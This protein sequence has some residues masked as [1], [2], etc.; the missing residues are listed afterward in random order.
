MADN[1]STSLTGLDPAISKSIATNA[2]SQGIT[3]EQ[4]L[5]NRGGI[6]AQ[7]YFKD[8][9]DPAQAATHAANVAAGI[10]DFAAAQKAGKVTSTGTSTATADLLAQQN[11]AAID[12]NNL[13]KRQSAYDTLY[14][15]FNKYGLGSIK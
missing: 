15:E 7:G 4:Y 1:F 8:T 3:A 9:Y 10:T 12:A 6:N 5:A 11:Q 13:Q 2:K 14:N